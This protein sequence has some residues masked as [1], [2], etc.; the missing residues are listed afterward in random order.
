MQDYVLTMS[1]DS[2]LQRLIITKWFDITLVSLWFTE[3]AFLLYFI[4]K[5]WIEYGRYWM[6][7][8]IVL[9][10]LHFCGLASHVAETMKST[11]I[12]N[13]WFNH[14][15]G[16][17]ELLPL[18]VIPYPLLIW[19]LYIKS[20]KWIHCNNN[21]KTS[22]TA[23][24]NDN[25]THCEHTN[26]HLINYT[27]FAWRE[28]AH[29]RHY[30]FLI[31]LMI[32]TIPTILTLLVLITDQ[33]YDSRETLILQSFW[34][35]ISFTSACVRFILLKRYVITRTII[36][37][38]IALI[39]DFLCCVQIIMIFWAGDSVGV[40]FCENTHLL[41]SN[42]DCDI[43]VFNGYGWSVIIVMWMAAM[44]VDEYEEHFGQLFVK[45]HIFFY[46]IYLWISFMWVILLI[47]SPFMVLTIRIDHNLVGYPWSQL[48][49][50]YDKYHGYFIENIFYPYVFAKINYK[51]NHH[52]NYNL[53]LQP[54]SHGQ[55]RD[56]MFGLDAKSNTILRHIAVKY[57]LFSQSEKR[58]FSK[59]LFP[60]LE[61]QRQLMFDNAYTH[62]NTASIKQVELWKPLISLIDDPTK[63]HQDSTSCCFDLGFIC[64]KLFHLVFPMYLLLDQ[65]AFLFLHLNDKKILYDKVF[66]FA[67]EILF[68]QNVVLVVFIIYAKMYVIKRYHFILDIMHDFKRYRHGK[69]EKELSD[70]LIKM[71]D[72]IKT[73]YNLLSVPYFMSNL[74]CKRIGRDIAF[75][76][77]DFVGF[78]DVDNY[79]TT[80]RLCNSIDIQKE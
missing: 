72:E 57:T 28:V 63:Q 60:A 51:C 58:E 27:V 19:W 24:K 59:K 22:I 54:P 16:G 48:E 41:I 14:G 32:Q 39:G 37:G 30:G 18:M 61:K 76:I 80:E 33:V 6:W 3:T 74:L 75:I 53:Q 64:G 4:V 26:H 66:I 70:N 20:P 8:P 7:L 52:H 31:S 69:S 35:G 23:G 62:E 79:V 65:I 50:G 17:L 77:L 78:R 67:N 11:N 13:C 25:N 49:N 38:L 73:N 71:K 10:F 68:L 1:Q 21:N 29:E 44:A 42:R 56:T 43:A 5:L 45:R 12:Y 2:Q 9:Q 36:L 47:F 34:L 40:A 46:I 15:F 55:I